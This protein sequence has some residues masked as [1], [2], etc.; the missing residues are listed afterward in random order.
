MELKLI[1]D[2]GQAAAT[3]SASDALFGRD[4]N[5]SLVHQIVVAYQANGRSGNRAQKDRAEV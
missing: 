5:E 2:Q 1:N 4:F 3:V